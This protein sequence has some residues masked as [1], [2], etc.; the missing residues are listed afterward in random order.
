[1]KSFFLFCD[2][3]YLLENTGDGI[4]LNQSNVTWSFNSIKNRA[5]NMI[6]V[7]IILNVSYKSAR[8]T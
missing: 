4:S 5:A 6:D 2:I 1:M 8:E 7:R 3:V